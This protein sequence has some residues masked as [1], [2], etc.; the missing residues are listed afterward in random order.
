MINASLYVI[1]S[2][3]KILA[4]D[5]DQWKLNKMWTSFCNES[6]WELKEIKFKLGVDHTGQPFYWPIGPQP[7]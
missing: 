6:D 7:L 3:G 4:Y 2:K 5:T 1:I